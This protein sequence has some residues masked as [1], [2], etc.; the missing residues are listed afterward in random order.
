MKESSGFFYFGLQVPAAQLLKLTNDTLTICIEFDDGPTPAAALYPL[1]PA[2]HHDPAMEKVFNNPALS[3]F[4]YIADG[5]PIHVQKQF[6]E[7]KVSVRKA[8]TLFRRDSPPTHGSLQQPA[9]TI[10][11]FECVP[12]TSYTA[13][14]SF[15]AFLYSG[16][17]PLLESEETASDARLLGQLCILAESFGVNSLYRY[18][19]RRF[20]TLL[21]AA[22]AVEL[23]LL[24]GHESDTVQE[25]IVSLIC[26]EFGA[27]RETTGFQSLL[28]SFVEPGDREEQCM[29]SKRFLAVLRRLKTGTAAMSGGK[30][31]SDALFTPAVMDPVRS[32][33]FRQLLST[34]SVADVRFLI[35]GK[36][37][38]AQKCVLSS[39]SDFFRSMFSG[40]WSEGGV[41]DQDRVSVVRIED[42]SHATFVAMLNYIYLLELDPDASL[43]ELGLL[44]ACADKYQIT[45]LSAL[46][47]SRISQQMA[48]ETISH[49]LFG[50]AYQCDVLISLAQEYFVRNFNLVRKSTEFVRVVRSYWEY[51]D[52]IRSG[53][54]T[55][56]LMQ[57]TAWNFKVMTVLPEESGGV[58]DLLQPSGEAEVLDSAE[59]HAKKKRKTSPLGIADDCVDGSDYEFVDL[60]TDSVSA[61]DKCVDPE[62]RNTC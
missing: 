38:F 35:E 37:V 24:F 41:D 8:P 58:D 11:P 34:P 49:F 12:N 6:V 61:A 23:L 33:A 28:S 56:I 25:L 42:F 19:I 48:P 39:L 47:L 30:S 52:A 54:W 3:D 2:A 50:Y 44:Y 17:L 9:C 60:T 4:S 22:N 16:R 40:A 36:V 20:D 46:V 45:D 31:R 53:I 5:N 10:H 15:L 57:F 59:I 7:A 14:H 62:P 1:F 32:V 13:L 21:N 51:E 55:Q 26:K 27:V 29:K 43:M 18:C